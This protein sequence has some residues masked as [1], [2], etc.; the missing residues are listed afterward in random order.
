MRQN[1]TQKQQHCLIP[2]KPECSSLAKEHVPADGT[3]QLALAL[4]T[5][6]KP[7]KACARGTAATAKEEDP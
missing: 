3:K 5:A 4:F 6:T 2:R 1:K 7:V